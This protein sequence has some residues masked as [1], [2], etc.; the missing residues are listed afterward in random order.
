MARGLALI[1][2]QFEW[3]TCKC[4]VW[5]CDAISI[6]H[7]NVWKNAEISHSPIGTNGASFDFWAN[8]PSELSCSGCSKIGLSDIFPSFF[9]KVSGIPISINS[10]NVHLDNLWKLLKKETINHMYF[11][12]NQTKSAGAEHFID[13]QKPLNSN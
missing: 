12:G 6:V 3:S 10:K 1:Q 7:G 11:L 9:L 5:I 2:L 4:N 8:F 13:M